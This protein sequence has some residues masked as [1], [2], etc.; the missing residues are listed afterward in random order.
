MSEEL[1]TEA[2]MHPFVQDEEALQDFFDSLSDQIP[3]IE[4]DINRLKLTPND[5]MVLAELF[6]LLHTAKGDAAMCKLE[7]AVQ[8][9]HPIESLLVRV[10]EGEVAFTELLAEI[11]LLATDRLEMAVQALIDKEPVSKLRLVDL[12]RGLNHLAATAPAEI[13]VEASQIIK[14]VT[15]F[16]MPSKGPE[17]ATPVSLRD[18]EAVLNDLRFFRTLALQYETRSELFHGRTERQLHLALETNKV[19]GNP[20]DPLQ[21][22][23]AVYMHDIGMLFVPESLWMSGKRLSDE[24]KAQLQQHVSYGAGLLMRMEGW[25]DAA[26]IV[27]QHHERHDGAGYPNRLKSADIVPG[28]KLMSIIDTFESVMLKHTQ[29][30]QGRSLVRAI[31]EVNAGDTQFAPEWITPFNIVIRLMIED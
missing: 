13:D 17:M 23:A 12:V 16:Q 3:T 15:G 4:R 29:R 22:E 6:R 2:L 20:I 14:T 28:A 1:N 9:V 24:E 8:I 30:G 27:L 7:F 31:A 21:L 5:K 10:R 26:N 11:I 25:R 19:A 18:A